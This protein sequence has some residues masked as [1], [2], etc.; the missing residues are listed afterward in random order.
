MDPKCG[1][2]R[3]TGLKST[4]FPESLYDLQRGVHISNL[5]MILIK[6]PLDR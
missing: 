2:V 3:S 4:G 6:L 5:G 1:Y